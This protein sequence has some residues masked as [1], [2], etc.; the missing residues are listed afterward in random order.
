MTS[1]TNTPAMLKNAVGHHF[2]PRL[3]PT[4]MLVILVFSANQSLGAKSYRV[5]NVTIVADLKT[6]GSMAV[7]EERTYRFKGRF[8]Y[9]YRNLPLDPRVSFEDFQVSENNQPYQLS[10]SHEPGTFTV[11]TKD[12]EIEVR[13]YYRANRETRTFELEYLV[14]DAVEK[15]LDGAVL[16]Y[17]FIGD[18]FR[19]STKTVD[20][21]VNPP[22]PVDQW[23]VRQW[24]HGP[25]WGNSTTS[26]QG[27]V[28]ATCENLPKKRFF[29]LRILYPAELFSEAPQISDYIIGEITAEENAWA[30]EAN[31]RREQYHLDAAALKKRQAIGAWALPLVVV[32][33]AV[34]F[35][36]IAR[37][38]GTRPTVPAVASSSSE[39]PS[40][41]PPAMV[42]Y[43]LHERSVGPA[44]MM[45]TLMDLARR[46]FLEFREEN[47]LGKDF[48]GREKWKA[49][50]SWLLK[51]EFYRE[52]GQSLAEFENMLITFVFED[53]ADTT[54][55]GSA[56]VAVDLETFKKKKSKVQKF[57]GTWSKQVKEE[58]TEYGFFDQESFHGRNQGMM[59]GGFLLVL[60]LPMIP[61][62]HILALI[63]AVAGAIMMIG[64]N[65]IVHHTSEGMILEKRWKSLKT[66][67]KK[68]GFQSAEPASVLE[69]IEP[70][71]IY[72][73]IMGMKKSQLE[74][75]GSII[76][77][78]KGVYYMPWYHH[79]HSDGGFASN[80]FGASFSTAVA[81]VNSAM[82]SSTG[83]GGG[84]SGGGGGGAGGG[85]GGAG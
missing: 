56:T 31:Q 19:K 82:S 3:L 37:Q 2:L 4:L 39:V 76:P 16:Y 57:F 72:G 35:F 65:G 8:K 60:A 69:F 41:L 64:S 51:S 17:K 77:A 28:S 50:H 5:E 43:L 71:F 49:R 85:G 45:A 79:N 1:Q 7:S 63:P 26:D 59:L 80:S 29:E 70:Y 22:R 15:H 75:L 33:V 47:E 78:E 42:G 38:Y 30:E 10:D 40:D 25:L 12:D 74:S 32:L 73:V 52:N 9:A 81:S 23:K 48:L 20:I 21:T 61:L 55:A 68:Q 84:A 24:A 11:T 53:L 83:A 36:K 58:A 27:V 13:W 34:W 62:V 44:S 14:K 67:L 6:D 46:G 18:T 54:N 66:Y